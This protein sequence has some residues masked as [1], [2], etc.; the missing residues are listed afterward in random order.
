MKRLTPMQAIR[1][2]CLDCSNNSPK[3]VTLC[4]IPECEL[5]PFRF[6]VRPETAKEQGKEIEAG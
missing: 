5:Y 2:K 1:K 4:P 3:E 6:G